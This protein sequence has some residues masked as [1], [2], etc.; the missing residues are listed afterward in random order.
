MKLILGNIDSPTYITLNP[1]D[2]LKVNWASP[3]WHAH[4]I[5]FTMDT[6]LIEPLP[7]IHLS[8]N[9]TPP[10]RDYAD[11][12]IST[13]L[14][15]ETIRWRPPDIT[16]TSKHTRNVGGFIVT[17]NYITIVHD[18]ATKDIYIS[19]N[20]SNESSLTNEYITKIQITAKAK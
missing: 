12:G 19:N 18:R 14:R 20:N 5:K 16:R 7:S 1:E 4:A 6:I 11:F 17:S 15:I 8:S 13:K 3:K 9:V 10:D 2:Q